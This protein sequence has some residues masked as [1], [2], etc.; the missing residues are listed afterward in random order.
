MSSTMRIVRH[1]REHATQ[2]QW[3]AQCGRFSPTALAIARIAAS[4]LAKPA[5]G[6]LVQPAPVTRT[7]HNDRADVGRVRRA[8]PTRQARQATATRPSARRTERALDATRRAFIFRAYSRFCRAALA[9]WKSAHCATARRKDIADSYGKKS[10]RRG[11][12]FTKLSVRKCSLAIGWPRPLIF[13]A[14]QLAGIFFYER[15]SRKKVC[16]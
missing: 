15:F 14:S 4:A 8:A 7:T 6:A 5:Q 3:H 16:L 9:E 1:S 13:P 2:C 10:T 12:P 11:P